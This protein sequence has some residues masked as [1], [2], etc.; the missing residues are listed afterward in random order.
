MKGLK[1][2]FKSKN[3]ISV[4]SHNLK[5]KRTNTKVKTKRSL[6]KK[7]VR[8]RQIKKRGVKKRLVKNPRKKTVKNKQTTK[9]TSEIHPILEDLNKDQRGAV[10][11]KNKRVLVLAGAGSGKTKTLIQKAIYLMFHKNV[12]SR[13][14]LAI[15][16]TKNAASEMV[17]RLILYADKDGNYRKILFNKKISH[18]K[19]QEARTNYINKY[20]WIKN[21]T[22]KT[23]HSL[24]YNIMRTRG[25]LEFDNKFKILVNNMHKAE[26]ESRHQAKERTDEILRDVI[27]K[28]CED[29]EFLIKLKRYIIDFYVDKVKDYQEKPGYVDYSKPFT[30]LRGDKVRSKS[31][32][33]IADWLY[34]HNI[35]YIYEPPINIKDF[36]FKPDFF[37]PSSNTYIE[38]VSNLSKGMKDKEEQFE[39]GNYSIFKTYE[40]MTKDI[41]KFHEALGRIVFGRF[42]KGIKKSTALRY[43]EEFKSYGDKLKLFAYFVSN[44][45]DKIKVSNYNFDEIYE[46]G[47]GCEHDR[48]RI[49]YELLK[50]IFWEYKLYC[51]KKSYLDFNDLMI[52]A[53]DLLKKNPQVKTYYQELFKYV[54]VDEFQDVNYTQVELLNNLLNKNSQLF[55]VGDDWQSIYGF[56]GSEVEYIVNFKTYFPKSSVFK[57]GVNYRSNDVIVNASN[58]VIKNNKFKLDK[59]IKSLNTTDKK[60]YLYCA[61]KEEEDGVQKVAELIKKFAEAGYSKED[62]L[63]LYRRSDTYLPYRNFFYSNGLNVQ[64]RTIH[65][66]KGLEAKVVIIVGLKEGMGGFPNVWEDDQIFQIIKKTNYDRLMEEERRLFYVALTRAKDELFLISEQ[67]NESIFINEIPGKFVDRDNFLILKIQ[68]PKKFN[69][70]GCSL[71]ISEEYSYCPYCG[72]KILIDNPNKESLNNFDKEKLVNIFKKWRMDLSKEKNVPPYVIMHDKTI[73]NLLEIMPSNKEDLLKVDGI[74]KSKVKK[75]GD[76]ILE[77]IKMGINS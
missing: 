57:L 37:I 51:E 28:L 26:I 77:I 66:S 3:K 68:K 12:K 25:S 9:K 41:N 20:P 14:I 39:K 60:I 30:T 29:T 49:F 40:E 72:F 32:R 65:S 43:N 70:S 44:A 35:N 48:V 31:E 11:D 21:I 7:P 33:C 16:F 64:A 69:C 52:K 63:I 75:Y 22:V 45:I 46:R 8:K 19:K 6:T 50:P 67:G 42:D 1:M 10:L 15:T 4:S 5:K 56:R 34:C 13:N 61:Q 73:I 59:K 76:K 54:L 47:R 53:V 38:H 27:V 36:E 74:G 23:F 24:C 58:E 62:I 2:K 71:E 18:I 55:C 17:D